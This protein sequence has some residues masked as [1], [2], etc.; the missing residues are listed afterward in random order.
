MILDIKDLFGNLYLETNNNT[1]QIYNDVIDEIDLIGLTSN[2]DAMYFM[3]VMLFKDK[4]LLGNK[5][6]QHSI[7]EN[8]G[9]N[10]IE[11][12]A[13]SHTDG[14]LQKDLLEQAK[15]EFKHAKMLSSL[16][17][18][19]GYE[20]KTFEKTSLSVE[21]EELPSFKDY[22]TF[23][24]FIHAAEIRTL[25]MLNQYLEIIKDMSDPNLLQMNIM[26]KHIKSDEHKH[27][28]YTGLYIN[29]W[30][31]EDKDLST[32]LFNCFLYTNKET[33]QEMSNMAKNFANQY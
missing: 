17:K 2:T 24:C 23:V 31:V 20:A 5:L 9:G 1:S 15:D 13:Q 3:N 14:V 28:L 30:L 10:L 27:A 21:D 33:W 11:N 32:T 26:L 8:M 25:I 16:I 18:C 29:K 19:T 7:Y 12:Y 4:F 6:Y 22:K